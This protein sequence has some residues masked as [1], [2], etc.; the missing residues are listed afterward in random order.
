MAYGKVEK[1]KKIVRSMEK[2]H[3]PKGGKAMP[4]N[5]RPMKKAGRGR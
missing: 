2:Q 5:A 1:T 4:Q 3:R